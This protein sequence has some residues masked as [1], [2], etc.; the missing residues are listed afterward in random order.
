MK[1][2]T[3]LCLSVATIFSPLWASGP[4]TQTHVITNVGTTDEAITSRTPGLDGF[5]EAHPTFTQNVGLSHN[6]MQAGS[7]SS[8]V[9]DAL[10]N[11]NM[12]G[13]TPLT[14]IQH[15]LFNSGDYPTQF[16][17]TRSL[18]PIGKLG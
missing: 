13:L 10:S 2:L 9:W 4:M 15:S 11:L 8:T 6:V 18:K 17:D 3:G 7:V 5:S 1:M 12:R 14:T 16:Q